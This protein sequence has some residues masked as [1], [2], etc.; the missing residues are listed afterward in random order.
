MRP[1]WVV[2]PSISDRETCLCKVHENLSFL[3]Q[4]LHTLQLLETTDVEVIAN[5]ICCDPAS[6]E[7]MYDECPKCRSNVYHLNHDYDYDA[8]AP[9]RFAQWTTEL[10]EKEEEKQRK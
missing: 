8:E 4:K 9:V 3:V 7:C 5:S 2:H 10:E 1:F 6:K